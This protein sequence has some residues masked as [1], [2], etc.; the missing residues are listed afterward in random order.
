[1][2]RR[3]PGADSNTPGSA[4][5]MAGTGW[6]RFS[7][8]ALF[9]NNLLQRLNRFNKEMT[10]EQT[11][12]D[13]PGRSGGSP[14]YPRTRRGL[15]ALCRPARC[16]RSDVTFHHRYAFRRVHE[17]ERYDAFT[18]TP[19]A[20]GARSGVRRPEPVHRDHALP[21]TDDDPHACRRSL[22]RRNLLHAP[23]PHDRG[24][25]AKTDDCGS[26]VFGP[27]RED[28]RHMAV[29]GTAALC[30]LAGGASTIIN[31]DLANGMGSTH[32]DAVPGS[33]R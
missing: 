31:I 3:R 29:C 20:R 4:A 17:R 10:D 28:R 18:G 21:W 26:P 5:N 15:R 14:R 1:M 27:V 19:L 9:S 30:R 2:I 6:R 7:K 11:H 16:T 33:R 22:H 13:L 32:A 8:P 25:N 23:S 24:W 12:Y